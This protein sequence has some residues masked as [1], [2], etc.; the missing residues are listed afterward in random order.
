MGLAAANFAAGP[1]KKKRAD[2]MMELGGMSY[3]IPAG[4]AQDLM[5]SPGS[6]NENEWMSGGGKE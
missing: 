2:G 6:S 4:A 1:G 5:T 3:G